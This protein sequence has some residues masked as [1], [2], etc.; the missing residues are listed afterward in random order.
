M[1]GGGLV[2]SAKLSLSARSFWS[3]LKIEARPLLLHEIVVSLV[4]THE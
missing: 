2:A 1:E 4:L 3:I